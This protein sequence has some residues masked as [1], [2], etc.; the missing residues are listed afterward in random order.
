MV[1]DLWE[2]K[3]KIS[4]WFKNSTSRARVL[5]SFW[6]SGVRTSIIIVYLQ[7]FRSIQD[8]SVRDTAIRIPPIVNHKVKDVNSDWLADQ[9]NEL[10]VICWDLGLIL[11]GF[12]SASLLTGLLEP[13]R[14][15]RRLAF[16]EK[17]RKD[18]QNKEQ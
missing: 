3:G 1:A 7:R 2:K 5:A 15:N 10:P 12:Q 8:L 11:H 18:L 13:K 9:W 4:R 16:L 6:W 17:I 14:L